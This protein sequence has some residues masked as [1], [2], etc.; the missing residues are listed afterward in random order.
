M[1][2]AARDY[3]PLRAEASVLHR[4]IREHLEDFLRAAADRADGAGLSEFV[5]REFREFLSKG[6]GSCPKEA[7]PC[8]SILAMAT[9]FA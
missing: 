4:V 7:R 2:W 9:S 1:G 6:R 8:S 5:A 3:Q